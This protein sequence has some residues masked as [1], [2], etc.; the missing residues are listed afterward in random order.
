MDSRELLLFQHPTFTLP[1]SADPTYL[2]SCAS[3]G[4]RSLS[5]ARGTRLGDAS[6]YGGAMSGHRK[7]IR[8]WRNCQ[9]LS[10]WKQL[11]SVADKQG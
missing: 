3:W 10:M 5:P 6:R 8:S 4:W 2:I 7:L 11:S 1:R 9:C